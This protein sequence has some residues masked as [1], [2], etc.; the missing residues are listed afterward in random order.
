MSQLPALHAAATLFMVGL[1][2][3]IQVVHY[4][5]MLKVPASGFVEYERSHTQRMGTLL[6]VPAGIEITTAVAL[7]WARP[8]AVGLASV[9]I[10]GALLAAIWIIT[11]FVQ[12][13]LH[14]RLSKGHDVGLI[15]QL[16]TSNWWRT[17]AWT[18]RGILVTSMLVV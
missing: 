8:E 10:A 12:V 16:V 15:S 4:P 17:A 13:P 7:I 9:M 1:I 3:T 5:L 2:W 18:L 6:A 11:A 14:S